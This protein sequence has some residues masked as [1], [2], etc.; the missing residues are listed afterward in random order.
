MPIKPWRATCIQMNS[1]LATKAADCAAAWSVIKGNVDRAGAL[2]EAACG[3]ADSPK[4][5]VLPEF[6]LQGPPHGGTG[7][8]WSDKAGYPCRSPCT[9]PP[10]KLSSPPRPDR[11]SNPLATPPT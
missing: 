2:I 10:P 7:R 3:H 1:V 9:A 11:A 5:G 6:A 8:E 4:V